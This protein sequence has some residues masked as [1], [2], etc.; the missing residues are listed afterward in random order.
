VLLVSVDWFVGI[1]RAFGNIVG[2]CAAAI[3]VATWEK[4]IDLQ[5]VRKT[6][7]HT[8]TLVRPIQTTSETLKTTRHDNTAGE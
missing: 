1:A 8:S 7:V 5:H 6:L 2:N 4:D 3:V